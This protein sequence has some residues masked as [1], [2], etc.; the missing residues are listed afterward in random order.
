MDPNMKIVLDKFKVMR[1][2]V[3]ELQTALTTRI[4]TVE[5]TIAK[6][7]GDLEAAAKVQGECDGRP[8]FLQQTVD[9][10]ALRKMVNRVFPSRRR[11]RRQHL[12]AT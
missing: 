11:L 4:D 9:V 10:G 6:R 1:G 12:P 3:S 8:F 7:F 2:T 5:N